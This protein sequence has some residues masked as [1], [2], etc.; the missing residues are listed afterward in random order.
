MNLEINTRLQW[1]QVGPLSDKTKRNNSTKRRHTNKRALPTDKLKS[2]TQSLHKTVVKF[3][4]LLLLFFNETD[5][6]KKCGESAKKWK[7]DLSVVKGSHLPG[8]QED[9]VRR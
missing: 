8:W 3:R 6:D 5:E 2:K 9:Y 1:Q 7:E 4:R